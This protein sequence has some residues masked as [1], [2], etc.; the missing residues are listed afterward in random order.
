MHSELSAD[1]PTQASSRGSQIQILDCESLI[2]AAYYKY[3]FFNYE[4]FPLRSVV[5]LLNQWS[6][7]LSA[8]HSNNTNL[9]GN[10][11]LHSMILH[12]HNI[13]PGFIHERVLPNHDELVSRTNAELVTQPAPCLFAF[14][15]EF[16][17]YTLCT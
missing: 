15:T 7:T 2:L 3:S 14:R 12:E 8:H 4:G 9:S 6:S 16:T 1:L 10:L 5:T 17:T 11:K 13:N